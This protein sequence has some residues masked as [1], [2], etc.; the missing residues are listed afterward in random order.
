MITDPIGEE[1]PEFFGGLE[2]SCRRDREDRI[3][4]APALPGIERVEARFTGAFFEPHR[5]DTYAIGVTL[6]GVQTFRYRGGRQISLPGRII[7]LHPDEIH[8]GAAGTEAGLRYRMLYLDP[9]LV[10]RAL[11]EMTPLPFVREPVLSDPV[12]QTALLATLGRL[13]DTIDDLALDDLIDRIAQGLARHGKTAGGPAATVSAQRI[14]RARDYLCDNAL[15]VVR[16]HELEEVTGLDRFA[17]ARQFRAL[18]ATSPHR[19]LIMRRLDHARRLITRGEA[20]ADIAAAVG[21]ADQSHLTRHFK[22]AFGIT[23]GRWAQVTQA[24]RTANE[25]A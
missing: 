3:R 13:D 24:P 23:P 14:H 8:D 16:S 7:V 15:R 20:L 18:F 1:K 22:K 9:A 4:A 12:L 2:H 19:F 10:H 21:F 6:S 11:G 25:P 17:L 5:H